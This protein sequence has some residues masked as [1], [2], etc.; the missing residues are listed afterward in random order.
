M[1]RPMS[2]TTLNTPATAPLFSKKLDVEK[3]KKSVR[4]KIKIERKNGV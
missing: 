2:P 3:K 1:T 4:G